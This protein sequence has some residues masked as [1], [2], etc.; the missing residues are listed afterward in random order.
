MRERLSKPS[1]NVSDGGGSPLETEI[2]DS[3]SD[4]D[5]RQ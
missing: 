4:S 2:E 3:K 5:I 1:R